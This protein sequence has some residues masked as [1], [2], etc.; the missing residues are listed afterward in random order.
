MA[1]SHKSSELCPACGHR[2]IPIK[3]STA[4]P[5]AIADSI[6]LGA[7]FCLSCM[8][9]L[10][11][12]I[13]MYT[14]SFYCERCSLRLVTKANEASQVQYNSSNTA[15]WPDDVEK[16]TAI[17]PT[18][19]HSRFAISP[20]GF[21]VAVSR[22]NIVNSKKRYRSLKP[23][24]RLNIESN[25]H[26]LPHKI[27][28][29]THPGTG[30]TIDSPGIPPIIPGTQRDPQYLQNS[31]SWNLGVLS[32][33]HA[34]HFRVNRY[35]GDAKSQEI[36][37][38]GLFGSNNWNAE[39]HMLNYKIDCDGHHTTSLDDKKPLSTFPML[40]TEERAW[41]TYDA[42]PGVLWTSSQG[43]LLWNQRELEDAEKCKGR[44]LCLVDAYDRL[45]VVIRK[46]SQPGQKGKI[47]EMRVYAELSE[48]FLGSLKES[49]LRPETQDRASASKEVPAEDLEIPKDLFN[50]LNIRNSRAGVQR[51]GWPNARDRLREM[52]RCPPTVLAQVRSLHV[53][54]WVQRGQFADERLKLEEWQHAPTD[55][56][57]DLFASVMMAMTGLLTLRWV[58]L[59]DFAQDFKEGF[60]SRALQLPS[61]I[62]LE[63][64]PFC[65][66]MVEVCPNIEALEAADGL[67]WT[68]EK[69]EGRYASLLIEAAAAAPKLRDFA[70]RAGF[71]PSSISIKAMPH[72]R[73]VKLAGR[74]PKPRRDPETGE[75]LRVRQGVPLKEM[76]EILAELPHL[77]Q[78]SLPAAEN[79]G[80]GGGLE[81]NCGNPFVGGPDAADLNYRITRQE[82]IGIEKAGLIV[83]EV[84][85]GLTHL[86][87]DGRKAVI[88]QGES[89]KVSALWPWTGRLEEYLDEILVRRAS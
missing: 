83:M 19:E 64:A 82:H 8:C 68:G 29:I 78:L 16:P 66:Y 56:L 89:G 77:E 54:V 57:L 55:E 62:K 80:Y 14:K 3:T 11:K 42:N 86:T 20:L 47:R 53:E 41:R 52:Q 70:G 7:M 87:I 5:T 40:A 17:C 30:Y 48:G 1:T 34:P 85:P 74:I 28:D 50:S 35:T 49:K 37:Q 73:S 39:V 6:F 79:L 9:C 51:P 71:V 31:C 27:I 81:Y 67:S 4:G 36:A 60:T 26:K 46:I 12:Q 15:P 38:I 25:S 65:E 22:A 75:R 32:T 2:G 69:G 72:L 33:I 24:Q 61:V 44:L 45:I 13:P 63:L 10:I 23:V 21:P 88:T 76:L 43:L 58:I 18:P 59:P 84:L